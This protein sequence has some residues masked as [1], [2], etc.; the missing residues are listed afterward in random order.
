MGYRWSYDLSCPSWTEWYLIHQT[1]M[2]S[3]DINT[4]IK[5]KSYI[6]NGKMTRVW[7]FL[8]PLPKYDKFRN[9]RVKVDEFPSRSSRCGS[10]VTNPTSIH[11]DV[12]LI[13][14]LSIRH[15]HELWCMLQTWLGFCIA[16]VVVYAGRCSSNLTP[17]L[18]TFICCRCNPKK[19]NKLIK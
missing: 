11:E 18:G 19:Q 6:C 16:M 9:Q 7:S 1:V 15:C 3:V 4:A 10:A 5:W 12:G 13:P 2:K 14:G 8:F 17:S